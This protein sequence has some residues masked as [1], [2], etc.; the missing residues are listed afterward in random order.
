LSGGHRPIDHLFHL[1]WSPLA[2]TQPALHLQQ[3]EWLILCGEGKAGEAF[4][5]SL[6]RTGYQA[7]LLSA[8]EDADPGWSLLQSPCENGARIVVDLQ[9]LEWA[10]GDGSAEQDCDRLQEAVRRCIRLAERAHDDG[11]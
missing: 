8:G 10:S 2:L 1:S 7:H 11:V 5:Q 6:R 9:A 4:L 3:V